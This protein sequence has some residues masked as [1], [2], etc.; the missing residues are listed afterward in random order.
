MATGPTGSA[1]EYPG[2]KNHSN[3]DGWPDG[4]GKTSYPNNGRAKPEKTAKVKSGSV[5][6]GSAPPATVRKW[7]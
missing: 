3:R 6:D 5:S 4:S 2:G 1:R 7:P